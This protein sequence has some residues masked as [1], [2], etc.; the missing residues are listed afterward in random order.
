MRRSSVHIPLPAVYPNGSST[1]SSAR[2]LVAV[3]DQLRRLAR[4]S[5]RR[6]LASFSLG[7]GG[8]A[9]AIAHGNPIGAG[10]ALAS[11]L[12]GLKRQADPASAYLFQAQQ[13][14]SR[15]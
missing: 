5:W 7:I 4:R 15:P 13:G 9:L 8:S 6:P 3:S 12:L 2:R 11:G 14:L 10:I 1:S